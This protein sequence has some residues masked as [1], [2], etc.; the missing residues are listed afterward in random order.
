MRNQQYTTKNN[1]VGFG[2]YPKQFN[3]LGNSS[4][5]EKIFNTQNLQVVDSQKSRNVNEWRKIGNPQRCEF[6]GGHLQ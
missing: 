6:M 2:F 4:L 3:I 1:H 5:L